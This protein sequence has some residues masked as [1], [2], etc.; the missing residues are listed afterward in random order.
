M[1]RTALSAKRL[2]ILSSIECGSPAPFVAPLWVSVTTG[3]SVGAAGVTR[4]EPSV[5]IQTVLNREE[6]TVAKVFRIRV[7][8]DFYVLADDHVEATTIASV[9]IDGV[10]HELPGDTVAN[11][12]AYQILRQDAFMR[13]QCVNYEGHADSQSPAA[14]EAGGQ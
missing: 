8:A 14:V 1:R 5:A 6:K 10:N 7:E 11:L 2:L 4:R 12:H 13:R 3:L 9:L